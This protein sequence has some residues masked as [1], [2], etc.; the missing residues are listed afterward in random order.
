MVDFNKFNSFIEAV[1][2]KKHDFSSDTFK[3]ILTNV[4]PVATNTQKSN[5]TE[6]SAGSGYTAGG[7]AVTI[8]SSSQ[9]SG[10]YSWVITSDITWINSGTIGP[11]QY[12]T[13]Y[14]DTATNDEL[15]GWWDYGSPLT[16]AVIGD[17]FIA[18]IGGVTIITAS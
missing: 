1:F 8:T 18:D 14:N 2:E 15:V 9:S 5:L 17:R 10:T 3:L 4:A 11:F 6:I 7:A 12:A 13:L 16:M